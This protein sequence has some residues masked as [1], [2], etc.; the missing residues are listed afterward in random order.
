MRWPRD[1]GGRGHRGAPT[2]RRARIDDRLAQALQRSPDIRGNEIIGTFELGRLTFLVIRQRH[3]QGR[4]PEP[5]E[6]FAEVKIGA[7]LGVPVRQDKNGGLFFAV[8]RKIR[9]ID[10]VVLD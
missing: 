7:G 10:R 4:K 5:V 3:P 2:H 9:R 1:G 8:R 6:H